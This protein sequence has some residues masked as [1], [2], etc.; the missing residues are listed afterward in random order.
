MMVMS[1]AAT[2]VAPKKG[3]ENQLL[4][5]T[6]AAFA[7]AALALAL[8]EMEVEAIAGVARGSGVLAVVL[9]CR[10][11]MSCDC[12]ASMVSIVAAVAVVVALEMPVA[13]DPTPLL[14]LLLTCGRERRWWYVQV[15]I[16]KSA[17]SRVCVRKGEEGR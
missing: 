7:F 2:A 4:C 13:T 11:C 17:R 5:W 16:C 8:T 6:G 15:R 3:T 14:M 10:A 9:V 1:L 12:M